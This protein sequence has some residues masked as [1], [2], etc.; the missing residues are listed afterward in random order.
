MR[1]SAWR[2]HRLH[3]TTC[4]SRGERGLLDELYEAAVANFTALSAFTKPQGLVDDIGWG[5]VDWGYIRPQGPIDPAVNLHYLVALRAMIRWSELL[6]KPS[7]K[8]AATE[9][10]I[11][12][13]LAKT[14]RDEYHVAAL[15]LAAGLF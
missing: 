2:W 5:F 3:S 7:E 12:G 14:P 1:S 10:Q 11:A 6:K 8:Y 13:V 4:G 15:S 9:K